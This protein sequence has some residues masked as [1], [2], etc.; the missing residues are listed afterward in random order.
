MLLFP[1]RYQTTMIAFS[2]LLG[3]SAS[4]QEIA[5]APPTPFDRVVEL[6]LDAEDY[7]LEGRGPVEWVE[8]EAEF[9]GNLHLWT[10]SEHDLLLRVQDEMGVKLA[11][12]EDSGGGATPYLK[13]EIEQ[14]EV[15]WVGVACGDAG[16][17]GAARLHLCAAPEE[18]A[19]HQAAERGRTALLE[20]K[21]KA[22]EGDLQAAQ[23]MVSGA[24]D[25]LL[26]LEGAP[27]SDEAIQILGDLGWAGYRAGDPALLRRTWSLALAHRQRVFP[28]DHR[29]N[30]DLKFALANRLDELGEFTGARALVESVLESRNRTLPPDHPDVL[31]AQQTLGVTIRKMGDIPG[32]RRLF[33]TVV[34]ARERTLPADHPALLMA[35]LNLATTVREMGDIQGARSLIEGV[36]RAYEETL[37]ADHPNLLL[38]RSKLAVAMAQSGD[39]FGA[40]ALFEAVLQV[41]EASLPA[42]HPDLLGVRLLLAVT[43][44]EMGDVPGACEI[45]A[46]VVTS[47]ERVLPPTILKS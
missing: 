44:D 29:A 46:A 8:Y 10:N 19:I 16:V 28:P 22:E 41:G 38:A 45:F 25:V 5:P 9:S 20:A 30:L 34:R 43:M 36:I 14:G 37:P 15:F 26:D 6:A 11:E 4:P 21:E 39:Y 24:I 32:A 2:L 27:S 1:Y 47:H 12:D 33:E 17:T 42:D 40:R 31:A 7:S 13:L 3:L 18:D 35:R 23:R